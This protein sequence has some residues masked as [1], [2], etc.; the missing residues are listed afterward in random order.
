M[1]NH[2]ASF[3]FS[4]KKPHF[5]GSAPSED[6]ETNKQPIDSK[7]YH[8]IAVILICP[9]L[10]AEQEGRFMQRSSAISAPLLRVKYLFGPL[11]KLCNKVTRFTLCRGEAEK[12]YL[13]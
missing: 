8:C 10:K 2:A 3:L 9:W 5:K 7:T 13:T 12:N 4:K 6:I 1:S 11:V